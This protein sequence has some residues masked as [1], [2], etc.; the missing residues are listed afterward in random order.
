M[1]QQEIEDKEWHRIQEVIVGTFRL[2]ECQRKIKSIVDALYSIYVNLDKGMPYQFT[3]AEW[4]LIGMMDKSS[5]MVTHGINM[6]YPIL[7][8][9]HEFWKWIIE[10]K[11]SPYLKDN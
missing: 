8:R 9:D 2:C 7:N 1:E 5:D 4:L 3:G 10:I 6:E 11:D